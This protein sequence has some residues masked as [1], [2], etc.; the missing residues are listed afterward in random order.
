MIYYVGITCKKQAV[1][2]RLD[3][4]R[5]YALGKPSTT[6]KE[7]VFFHRRKIIRRRLLVGW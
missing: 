7:D 5:T 6:E 3:A 1:D 2:V 4:I